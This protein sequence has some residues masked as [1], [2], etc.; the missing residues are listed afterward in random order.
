MVRVG[1]PCNQGDINKEKPGCAGSLISKKFVATS[2]H[3]F[4][5]VFKK[6]TCKC[7][8]KADCW[9]RIFYGSDGVVNETKTI[10]IK[11]VLVPPGK[12]PEKRVKVDHDFAVAILEKNFDEV[13]GWYQGMRRCCYSFSIS[14]I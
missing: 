13:D 5:R 3:C 11:D 9:G 7:I 8:P 4:N 10:K 12:T 2:S 6:K 1:S 14:D